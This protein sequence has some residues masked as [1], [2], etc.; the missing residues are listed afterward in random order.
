MKVDKKILPLSSWPPIPCTFS[1]FLSS[2]PQTVPLLL[3]AQS[4]IVAA[5]SSSQERGQGLPECLAE[6]HTSLPHAHI[7]LSKTF[8]SF[9]VGPGGISACDSHRVLRPLIK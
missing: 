7:S 3:I 2:H 8:L 1:C 5:G 4:A 9:E 6:E